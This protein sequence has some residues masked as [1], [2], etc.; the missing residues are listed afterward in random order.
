MD[1]PL[2]E[3]V[4]FEGI[5]SGATGVAVDADSTPT[6]EIFEEDTDTAIRSGNFA[7]RTSKTGD[8]RGSDTCSAANGYDVGKW[9]N[10]VGSATIG[11]IA[12]KGIIKSF[13]ISAAEVTVGSRP[14]TLAV[15]AIADGAITAAKFAANALDAV[16]STAARTL[17]SGAGI[18][19]AKGTGVTGFNDI[20]AASVWAVAT[21]ELTGF[22]TLVSD[23]TTAVWGAGSRT[24]TS[25]GSLV[26]DIIT[27]Y[28]VAYDSVL[29]A[30]GT[31]ASSA[32]S[33]ASTAA[34]NA[35]SAAVAAGDAETA[36]VDAATIAG[37]A[38]TA[39]EAAQAA[40]EAITPAPTANE[41][42]LEV[43]SELMETDFIPAAEFFTNQPAV[44]VELDQ[45]A[46]DDISA[47]VVAGIQAIPGFTVEVTSPTNSNGS[48]EVQQ[49]D[50][51]LEANNRHQRITL[52]GSLPL[53]EEACTL[54]VFFGGSVSTYT[55]TRVVNSA[56]NYTLKFDLTGVQTAAMPVGE[57]SYE[58]ETTYFGTTNKWTPSKG[59]FT[60]FAQLG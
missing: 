46:I 15:G 11:G 36:A 17:T 57:F 39:A 47:G 45:E 27:A 2:D 24:L 10:V 13:R 59:K 43:K 1:I 22:G 4:H 26:A 37:Q 32:A 14:G 29:D 51:Y 8:Y 6:W 21:R 12:C 7:K 42:A 30:I 54:R 48:M 23:I 40:A 33:N 25:F 28:G 56:T 41:V 34:S 53:I 5:S 55:G 3:V 35:A 9:Y 16:W 49:G 60:V 44:S 50:A 19:L 18:A 58:V 52:T 38:K 31:L 20:T